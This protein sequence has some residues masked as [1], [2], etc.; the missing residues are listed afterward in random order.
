MTVQP[1][2]WV[3]W[4]SAGVQQ[5]GRVEAVSANGDVH[6]QVPADGRLVPWTLLGPEP[7]LTVIPWP[8]ELIAPS[9]LRWRGVPAERA[10]QPLLGA[11]GKRGQIALIFED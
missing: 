6:V 4:V 2:E 5:R 7:S 11:V 8:P 10:P 9:T 1:W 3:T